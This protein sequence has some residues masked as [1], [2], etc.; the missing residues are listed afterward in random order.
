MTTKKGKVISKEGKYFLEVEGKATAISDKTVSDP[1]AL[2]SMAGKAV[3]VEYSDGKSVF[4]VS[5]E[6]PSAGPKV[7]PKIRIT[8]Y[9]PKIDI[10]SLVMTDALRTN[11][12]AK[13]ATEGIITKSLAE[14]ISVQKIQ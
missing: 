4:P 11:L 5:I 12:A 3:E 6:V 7:R 13:M 9:L 1:A 2:K 8:C 10:S 14:K